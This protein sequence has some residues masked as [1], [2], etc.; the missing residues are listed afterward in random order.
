M[1]YYTIINNDELYTI[2]A[3]DHGDEIIHVNVNENEMID[4]ESM[5]LNNGFINKIGGSSWL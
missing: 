1:K 5:Y 3:Y 4:I 2:T